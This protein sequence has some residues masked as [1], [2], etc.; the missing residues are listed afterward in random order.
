MNQLPGLT[1]S[2]LECDETHSALNQNTN[3]VQTHCCQL[4]MALLVHQCCKV[5]VTLYKAGFLTI[6]YR[7]IWSQGLKLILQFQEHQF[8]V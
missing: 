7:F 3:K 1:K 4:C 5:F 8:C 6:K 2:G